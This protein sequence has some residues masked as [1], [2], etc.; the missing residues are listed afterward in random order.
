VWTFVMLFLSCRL[1]CGVVLVVSCRVVLFFMS[2][3]VSDLFL[4]LHAVS[5]L[6]CFSGDKTRMPRRVNP[7]ITTGLKVLCSYN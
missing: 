4:F 1:L 3:C 7:F 2:V 5:Q 6:F